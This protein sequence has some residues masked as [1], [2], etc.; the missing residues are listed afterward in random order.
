MRAL[1]ENVT[2]Q[3]FAESVFTGK[4]GAITALYAS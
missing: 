4:S 1:V 2:Q 3:G